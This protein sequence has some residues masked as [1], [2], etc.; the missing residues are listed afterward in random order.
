M[1]GEKVAEFS[2]NVTGQRFLPSDD[3]GSV[4]EV[5]V[6]MGGTILGNEA[7]FMATYEVVIRPDG[8]LDGHGQGAVMTPEGDMATVTGQ[9]AGRFT[10]H[11]SANS[12]RGSIFFHTASQKLARLNGMATAFEWDVDENGNVE[13]NLWE[14]K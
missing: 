14:W 4:V 1:L 12:F 6:Q 7:T 11:G 13:A 9:G 8:T 2:G 5:S 10:G 3:P